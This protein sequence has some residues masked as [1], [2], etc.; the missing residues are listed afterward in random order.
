MDKAYLSDFSRMEIDSE[1]VLQKPFSAVKTMEA[2]YAV[3]EDGEE[4][5]SYLSY[6][7]VIGTSLDREAYIAYQILEYVL[8]SSAAAPVKQRL[9][10]EGLGS[11]VS[12]SYDNGIL[13]PVFSVLVKNAKKE[14]KNRFVAVLKDELEK[15]VKEGIDAEA[16]QGAINYFEFK[17]SLIHWHLLLIAF[18]ISMCYDGGIVYSLGFIL[19]L[20]LEIVNIIFLLFLDL[21]ILNN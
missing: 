21:L 13:Q 12:A 3:S 15:I 9:V 19:S 8:F 18:F 10:K 5:K 6:N 20:N 17:V 16:I 7:T 14:N 11:E 1:I 4:A 2:E